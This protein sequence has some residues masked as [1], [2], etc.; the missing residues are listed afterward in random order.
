MCRRFAE[1]PWWEAHFLIDIHALRILV[2]PA[3]FPDSATKKE[4]E[5]NTRLSLHVETLRPP[6]RRAPLSPS[7]S[8]RG[9]G[10]PAV[11]IL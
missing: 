10:L 8:G 11:V 4:Q 3:S 5:W 6:V 1:L 7:S 2:S 9:H